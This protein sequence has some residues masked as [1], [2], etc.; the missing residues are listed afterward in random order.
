M[1][2]FS[3]SGPLPLAS[4]VFLQNADW[5]TPAIKRSG[6]DHCHSPIQAKKNSEIADAGKNLFNAGVDILRPG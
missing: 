5:R 2:S 3:C 1:F 4:A 6:S